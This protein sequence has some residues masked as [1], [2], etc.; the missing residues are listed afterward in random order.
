VSS[1]DNQSH[2][3]GWFA[4]RAEVGDRAPCAKDAE[5][6]AKAVGMS[7]QNVIAQQLA[8][9]RRRLFALARE[10]AHEAAKMTD[11]RD[12]LHHLV[13]SRS[14]LEESACALGLSPHDATTATIAAVESFVVASGVGVLW[15]MRNTK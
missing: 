13:V 14:V 12:A 11:A 2:S 10:R 1:S 7:V 15:A 4:F 9:K 6:F 8:E 3:Q 5:Q